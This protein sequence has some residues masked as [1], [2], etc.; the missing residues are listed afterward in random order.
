MAKKFLDESGV[1]TLWNKI[2]SMFVK[3]ANLSENVNFNDVTEGGMY[4]Y[5]SSITNGPDGAGSHGQLLVV[6]GAN[7]TIAQLCFPYADSRMFLRTGNTV[8]NPNG[9]WQGWV[10][11]AN[12]NDLNNYLPLSGGTINGSLEVNNTLTLAN[13]TDNPRTLI[14]LADDI[15]LMDYQDC[16]MGIKCN[17]SNDLGIR[18]KGSAGR[19]LTYM[20][21]SSGGTLATEAFVNNKGYQTASQ[22]NTLIDNKIPTFSFSNGVLTITTH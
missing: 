1:S 5:N 2:K 11:I 22:V 20:F 13:K 3:K 21:P 7:D 19:D 14:K 16:R 17:T 9:T 18:F 15:D 6:R 12:T 10:A 8:N 4:R